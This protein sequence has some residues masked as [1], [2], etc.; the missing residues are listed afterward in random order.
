[1]QL[2]TRHVLATLTGLALCSTGSTA[3]TVT[4][5]GRIATTVNQIETG[6]TTVAGTA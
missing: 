5:Y 6:N 4:I 2:K 1:M 3:Q